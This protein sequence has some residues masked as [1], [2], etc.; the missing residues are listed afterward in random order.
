MLKEKLRLT[1]NQDFRNIYEQGKYV[2]GK[3]LVVYYLANGSPAPRFGFVASKKIGK[4]H[5]R[6][7]AKRLLREAVRALIPQVKGGYDIIVVARPHIR[8]KSLTELS[9]VL[10]WALRKAGLMGGGK[11]EE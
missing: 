9:V 6:N 1:N 4:S 8:D 2:A 7:R 5:E 11:K 10:R 3:P